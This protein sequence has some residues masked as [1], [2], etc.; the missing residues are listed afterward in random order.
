MKRKYIIIIV[1]FIPLIFGMQSFREIQIQ[2]NDVAIEEL[3]A[4][5]DI[6]F[7]ESSIEDFTS[8]SKVENTVRLFIDP[9]NEFRGNS[10]LLV[11]QDDQIIL[12]LQHTG[13]APF[14]CTS[15]SNWST[16]EYTKDTLI[17]IFE[18]KYP[19]NYK[20]VSKCE[21]MIKVRYKSD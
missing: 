10:Y 1:V 16:Y 11:S 4:L 5:L 3:S 18:E 9:I 8:E 12:N 14:S 15:D 17:N 13:Y 21:D 7:Q 6:Y 20:I 19:N 2:F